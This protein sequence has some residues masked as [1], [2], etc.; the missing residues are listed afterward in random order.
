MRRHGSLLA[1]ISWLGLGE[2]VSRILGFVTTIILA[3]RVG[4]VAF[5]DYIVASAA[6]G[7]ALILA[8]PGGETLGVRVRR[9]HPD[10]REAF[11]ALLHLRLIG[12]VCAC[13]LLFCC[14]Y[15]LPVTN[16]Q[17]D[18]LLLHA[19]LLPGLLLNVGFLM[20]ADERMTVPGLG[21]VLQGT[22]YMSGVALLV[23]SSEDVVWVPMV[24]GAAMLAYAL[25]SIGWMNRWYELRMVSV[26]HLHGSRLRGLVRS[27]IPIVLSSLLIAV[28]YSMDAIMIGLMRSSEEAGMYGAAYRIVLLMIGG[29]ALL[30]QAFMPRL[31]DPDVGVRREAHRKLIRIMS[32]IGILAGGALAVSSDWMLITLYGATCRPAAPALMILGGVVCLVFINV[33]LAS[34]M[35][36]WGLERRHV[37]I[38]G[39]AAGVNLVLNL[40]LIPRWG[41]L[42]AAG[43]TIAA[44]LVVLSLTLSMWRGIQGHGSEFGGPRGAF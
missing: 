17:R 22:L 26:R 9:Q 36:L 37:M 16:L 32:T 19:L 2:V 39:T 10:D 1:N 14:A 3:R 33:A 41:M 44:E 31:A 13:I 40:I 15:V 23:W 42:G 6:A 38:V 27:A 30:Y 25:V 35:Q 7:Y 29:G 8:V 11:T 20:Q 21:R 43:A 28:Y 4:T 5:G 34:P 18:L 12:G 24:L